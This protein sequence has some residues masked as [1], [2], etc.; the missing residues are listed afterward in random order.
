MFLRVDLPDCMIHR[1]ATFQILKQ[2]K[3]MTYI[4]PKMLCVVLT[5]F[6]NKFRKEHHERSL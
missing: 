4:I 6:K 2:K 5:Q 3:E 1:A